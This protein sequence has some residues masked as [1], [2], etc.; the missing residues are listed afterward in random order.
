[1]IKKEKIVGMCYHVR[2]NQNPK[3]EL[4]QIRDMYV[5]NSRMMRD[6]ACRAVTALFSF[7]QAN[8]FK[9]FGKNWFD[10]KECGDEVYEVAAGR[11]ESTGE[12][13][14]RIPMVAF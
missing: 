14:K 10:N 7:E 5:E 6:P 12:K 2:G 8:L 9:V 4:K 1:M 3:D 11:K 13:P